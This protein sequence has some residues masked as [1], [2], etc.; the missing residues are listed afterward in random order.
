MAYSYSVCPQ[1]SKDE[2]LYSQILKCN[3]LECDNLNVNGD[4]ISNNKFSVSIPLT[5]PYSVYTL[6]LTYQKIG[7]IVCLYFPTTI[8]PADASGVI[9]FNLPSALHPSDSLKNPFIIVNS[10]PTEVYTM[11]SIQINESGTVDIYAGLNNE[12]FTID[13]YAGFGQQCVS[14]LV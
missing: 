13:N 11:G 5:G 3:D 7:D 2:S 10:A 1:I 6:N 9:S 12:S 14:Y 4:I 8:H